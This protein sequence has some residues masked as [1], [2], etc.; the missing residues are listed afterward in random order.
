MRL[1][2]IVLI[3]AIILFPWVLVP[4][5]FYHIWRRGIFQPLMKSFAAPFRRSLIRTQGLVEEALTL[6]YYR[7]SGGQCYAVIPRTFGVQ[8]VYGIEVRDLPERLTSNI[9]DVIRAIL[10]NVGLR[11][12]TTISLVTKDK[13]EKVR[14]HSVSKALPGTE[15][16]VEREAREAALRIFDALRSE[17]PTLK[18][19]LCKGDE[20]TE[21]LPLGVLR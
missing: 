9:G 11:G 2:K 20:V 12:G 15:V 17:S 16:D 8:Y 6:K 18:V 3:L 1:R 13:I 7:P 14:V 4:L 5:G 21:G 19:T 10:D